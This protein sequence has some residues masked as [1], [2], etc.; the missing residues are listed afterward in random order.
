MKKLTKAIAALMLSLAVA[1]AAGCT[2]PEDPNNP[3]NSG[4][5]GGGLSR[6]T[7]N[8][9]ANPSEGGTVSGG[10]AFDSGTS[11]TITAT[12]NEGYSF[13][14]WTKNGTQVST[15]PS[16]TFTVTESALYV[17]NFA[18]QTQA[19]TGAINGLFS[20]SATQ[21]VWFSQGN[22][23]YRASTNTW[24]FTANQYDYI[25]DANSN[26]SSSYS[27]WIDLFGWGTS[28]WNCGN[29][30]YRPW[31]SNNSCPEC[32][33][34]PGQYNL[35]GS[36]ANSDWGYYN[37][38][39]NGG[40]TTHQW[41]TLTQSEWDYVFN[42]RSTSSGIRY[43]KAQVAGVNGVILLPDDWSTSYYNLSSTNNS[44]SS[45]SSNVISASSWTSSLQAHGAVFLPAAGGRIGASV[46]NVGSCGYYWSASY[47]GSNYAW[48]VDFFDI[49][50]STDLWFCRYDGFSVRLVCPAQ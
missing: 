40:N 36:Y 7:I 45:F 27:G 50:L 38:I 15:N 32:Y 47:Y 3:N 37:A 43:A 17:A 26:I 33:G 42:T 8:V 5:G 24:Q 23:Q 30:Y 22:L 46:S 41:R 19:P 1:C 18:V 2:K 34:P 12:A 16:Y 6:F 13:Q 44:G 9:S 31:D 48:G 4:G 21:Q 28:G 10:G 25:G 49:N 20:V 11:Q 14:N 29:T 39:S 35:I